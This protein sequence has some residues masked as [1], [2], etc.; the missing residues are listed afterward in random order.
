MSLINKMLQELDKRHASQGATGQPAP[1]NLAASL[2]PTSGVRV[3]S[4]LFWWI[5]AVVM[6]LLIVWLAWVMWQ[7]TPR[8]IAT[9]LAYQ[10]RQRMQAVS[11]AP[12][13]DAVTSVQVGT[14]G[15][16][17]TVNPEAA[18]AASAPATPAPV[19]VTAQS[20]PASVATPAPAATTAPAVAA[21][22]TPVQ[23]ARTEPGKPVPQVDMLKLATAIVTPIP[24]RR[25]A[26]SVPA[27]SNVSN[28]APAASK[29]ASAVREPAAEKVDALKAAAKSE[30]AKADP[31][32]NLSSTTAEK[33]VAHR[34]EEPRVPAA[35]GAAPVVAMVEPP[36]IDKRVTSTPM[37][38]AEV[39]YRRGI[40]LVNQ[41]RVS[42]GLEGLRAALA[43]EPGHETARHTFVTL[44]MEQR[45]YDESY[46]LLQK[47][48]ELN[49]GNSVFASL[50]AR[51]L[52]ERRDLNGAL[53]ILRKYSP[54]ATG[55]ADYH[56]LAA[57]VLQRMGR[58]AEAVDE[59]Q[60]ALKISPQSGPWWVGLGISQEG[61]DRRKEAAASFKRAQSVGGLS[62]DL[63]A[64]V[65]Q[66]LR[67]LQ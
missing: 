30:L 6:L 10:H 64:F 16:P 3:G 63:V 54:S 53:S 1:Q 2:R 66:R 32:K 14:P 45:R 29:A 5:M 11:S 15:V 7:V 62:P 57:A 56:A 28:A 49:P 35:Q 39:E 44:L 9:D 60:A 34:A 47:G 48:L 37:E 52:I 12:P 22:A 25:G 19:A 26:K 23:P 8:P 50:V 17:G 65:D 27:A 36:R 42:E 31:A 13:P 43:I 24:E 38:R 59:Y 46:T 40:T 41:G 20:A 58:H 4:D 61:A 67:Q 21:P 55:N 18:T 51:I 33:S